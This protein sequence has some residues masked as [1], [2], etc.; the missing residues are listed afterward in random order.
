MTRSHDTRSISALASRQIGIVRAEQLH[1]LGLSE[2]RRRTL[3]GSGFLHRCYDD[4]FAVGHT[5]LS[6]NALYLAAA[7]ALGP[8]GAIA[9]HSAA[10]HLGL[11]KPGG[12]IHVVVPTYNGRPNR[13]NIHVHRQRLRPRERWTPGGVPCTTVCRTVMDIAASDPRLLNSVFEEAQ[14]RYKL[15]PSL[16]AAE[17]VMRPNHRGT[18]RL[19]LLLD[20][21]V[22]PGQVQSILELRFLKLC[23]AYGLPRPLTQVW[24]GRWRADFWFREQRVVVETDGKRWHAT[25]AKRRRDRRKDADIQAA[26]QTVLHLRWVDVVDRS[27]S[28]AAALHRAFA[29]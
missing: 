7:W 4:V 12:L 1:A 21:A 17:L 13:G 2:D 15:S 14:V 16:V 22:D 27:G 10:A 8:D 18:G 26:G 24:F 25:Q 28:V 3:L 6:Q 11:T 5:A 23:Q 19:R 9:H 20:D 29:G